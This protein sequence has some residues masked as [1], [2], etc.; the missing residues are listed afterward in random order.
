MKKILV[1]ECLYG[2]RAV[3]YDAK[4]IPL[5]DKLFLKWKAEGRLIPIC[6]EILGGLSTPRASAQRLG[7][8]ILT[9]NGE[10]VTKE[11]ILGALK[12]IE[13]AKENEIIFAIMKQNSPSC[14]SKV[15]YDGTFTNKKQPGQGLA[16][17]Y[18]RREGILVFSEDDIEEAKKY[19]EENE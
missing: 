11:Y 13:I 5:E 1:S 18:L 17:E 8:Q 7:D 3:R 14:G 15:I 9:E 4:E 19:L 10:D 12:I 6:P 16:V 2:G